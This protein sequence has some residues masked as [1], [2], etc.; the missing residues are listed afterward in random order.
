MKSLSPFARPG[1][2]ERKAIAGG[3]RNR[4]GRVAGVFLIKPSQK[5][6]KPD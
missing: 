6:S 1:L 5:I 4:S 2:V 3:F